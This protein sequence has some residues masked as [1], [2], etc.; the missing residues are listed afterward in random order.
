MKRQQKGYKK[1]L[2]QLITLTELE[3]KY[4]GQWDTRHDT[5]YCL[6]TNTPHDQRNFFANSSLLSI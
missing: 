1:S 3:N 5:F 4:S 6:M 2:L